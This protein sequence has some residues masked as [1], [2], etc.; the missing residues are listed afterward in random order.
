[1]LPFRVGQGVKPPLHNLLAIAWVSAGN[2]MTVLASLELSAFSVMNVQVAGDLTRSLGASNK[3]GVEGA[4]LEKGRMP[5]RVGRMP[6]FLKRY[7]N[8]EAA[9]LL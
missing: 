4:K 9:L 2:T 8:W 3:E 7:P 5:V 6:P 1:M